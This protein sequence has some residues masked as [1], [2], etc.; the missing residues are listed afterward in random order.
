SAEVRHSKPDKRIYEIILEKYS[1][2]PEES[3][4]IDD[5]EI[6]VKAAVMVGMKGLITHGSLEVSKEIKNA[7]SLY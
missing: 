1:L 2:N 7:L 6:N 3:L 4:F 5:L